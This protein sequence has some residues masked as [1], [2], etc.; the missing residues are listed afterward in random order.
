MP[1]DDMQHLA[2]FLHNA[3]AGQKFSPIYSIMMFYVYALPD[4][5]ISGSGLIFDRQ[6]D[7]FLRRLRML[8]K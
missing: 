2:F 6:E 4:D 1:S 7:R 8:A 5:E 3:L